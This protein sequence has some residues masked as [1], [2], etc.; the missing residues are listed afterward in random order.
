M[1]GLLKMKKN[2]IVK[3]ITVILAVAA[4]TSVV[5]ACAKKTTSEDYTYKTDISGVKEILDTD[6]EKYLKLVNK[7]NTVAE[8]YAPEKL[9]KVKTEYTFGGKNVELEESVVKAAE[10]MIAE[11]RADGI[12]DVYVTSGFRTYAYQK[13]LFDRY[14]NEERAANSDLTEEQ[15]KEKVL[16]YSAAPGTSEHQTGLCMDLMTTEMENLWNYGS[17]TPNNPY[18]KGFAETEAFEWLKTNAHRFGFILRF[19]EDKTKVT[20]YAYESWHYRFVGINAATE[21]YNE[22]ITL[23]EYLEK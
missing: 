2:T 13:S 10:A 1:K 12:K 15:I 6:D 5:T 20:G 7:K 8:D 17:E 16:S 22:G 14:C 4:M 23:E 19:P 21:I 9:G 11:M 3:L 18:D